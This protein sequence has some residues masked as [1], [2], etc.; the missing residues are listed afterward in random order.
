[1]LCAVCFASAGTLP[2]G[3]LLIRRDISGRPRPRKVFSA[4]G[5]ELGHRV[6]RQD[7]PGGGASP[8][9]ARGHAD[10]G[11]GPVTVHSIAAQMHDA[12]CVAAKT[13]AR[14]KRWAEPSA[15]KPGQPG[16][17]V[18]FGSRTVASVYISNP[19]SNTML[20]GYN[21]P[22]NQLHKF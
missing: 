6:S 12:D 14:A 10:P 9:H 5:V 17:E 8:F 22:H 1:M 19:W 7:R 16:D 13:H 11:H 4:F 21:Q 15:L 2:G 18:V 3:A 20:P